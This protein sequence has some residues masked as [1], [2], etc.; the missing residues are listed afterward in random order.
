MTDKDTTPAADDSEP[1][2]NES[3]RD[4]LKGMGAA[5]SMLAA[6]ITP[7]LGWGADAAPT[8]AK[9]KNYL[10]LYQWSLI[11]TKGTREFPGWRPGEPEIWC[12]TQKMSY[13]EGENVDLRVHT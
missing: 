12:Y 3:R 13:T 6:G 4:I 9:D 8:A 2:V 10:R 7:G 5:A 1:I 11:D